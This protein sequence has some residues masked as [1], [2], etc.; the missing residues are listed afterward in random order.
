M[1]V[2]KEERRANLKMYLKNYI[3]VSKTELTYFYIIAF[4]V[5]RLA[6]SSTTDISSLVKHFNYM[7]EAI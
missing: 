4:W 2:Q 5:F 3:G 1:C 6:Y 7:S